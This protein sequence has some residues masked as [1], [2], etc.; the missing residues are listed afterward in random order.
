MRAVRGPA[1]N[2]EYRLTDARVSQGSWA[3]GVALVPKNPSARSDAILSG[4]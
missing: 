3:Y 1:V 2:I 4:R